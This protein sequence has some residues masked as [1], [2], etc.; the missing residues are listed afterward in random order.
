MIF[1]RLDLGDFTFSNGDRWTFATLAVLLNSRTAQSWRPAGK[2][3]V[4]EVA[5]TFA[6]RRAQMETACDPADQRLSYSTTM[7]DINFKQILVFF[8]A[9]PSPCLGESATRS[10][11]SQK[12][13]HRAP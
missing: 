13:K 1:G 2:P 3:V 4:P 6:R 7:A 5:L 11:V 12:K 9:A 10:P 8:S